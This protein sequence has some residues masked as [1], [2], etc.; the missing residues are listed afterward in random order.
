[1][2]PRDKFIERAKKA[3]EVEPGNGFWGRIWD[4]VADELAAVERE[5]ATEVIDRAEQ[6]GMLTTAKTL[7]REFLES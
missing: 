2:T 3:T 5:T 1:M 6:L 4:S 7:R